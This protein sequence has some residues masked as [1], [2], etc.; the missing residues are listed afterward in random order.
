MHPGWNT[1]PSQYTM[2]T[3]SY[4][5]HIKVQI[6]LLSCEKLNNSKGIPQKA[7]LTR[8][9]DHTCEMAMV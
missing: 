4:L 2:Y 6:Q 8:G 9:R 5:G 3:H 1:C 7:N